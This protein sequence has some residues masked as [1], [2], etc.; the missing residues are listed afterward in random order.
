MV[1]ITSIFTGVYTMLNVRKKSRRRLPQKV[2]QL[3][4]APQAI[5]QGWSM[6][7]VNER[8]FR[9]LNIIDGYSSQSLAIEIDTSL[10]SL[11]VIRALEPLIER[12][13]KPHE[14]SENKGNLH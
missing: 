11:E 3:L 1:V 7:L 9:L 8:R 5:N 4:L 2:K 14:W 13:A 6:G 12:R 10:P